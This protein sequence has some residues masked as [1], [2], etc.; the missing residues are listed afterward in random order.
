MPKCVSINEQY[1]FLLID[2]NSTQ[3]QYYLLDK[4]D[5]ESFSQSTPTIEN[6]STAFS[7]GF[8]IPLFCFLMGKKLGAVINVLKD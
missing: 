4:N 5:A 6:I 1:N 3:C 8:F 2:N 7:V